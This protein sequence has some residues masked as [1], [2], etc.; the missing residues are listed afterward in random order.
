MTAP[1]PKGD[2]RDTAD[3]PQSLL[4]TGAS[5]GLGRALALH[6]AKPATVLHLWGRDEERL[7][8]TACAARNAGAMTQLTCMDLRDTEAAVREMLEQDRAA[9]FDMAY[10]VAG[11]GEIRAEN[12]IID[13]PD[14]VLRALQ[15]NCVAPAAMGAALAQ[16]MCLRGRGRIVMIGSAA[17]HHSLPFAA[18]Y[19]G[20]KAGL[21]RFTDAMRLA[22]KPYGVSITLAE[23]GF[24]DTPAARAISP[25]RPLQIS[26]EVA[27]RRIARAAM[28]GRPRLVTPWPF[29]V[30]Q[31]IDALLPR[32]ARDY[33]LSR[34]KP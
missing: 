3:T 34:L 2:I 32:I 33:M 17:A 4:I 14:L 27:A 13:D 24:I 31:K 10:F 5:G 19:A 12:A 22:V 15:T 29:A 26:P 8:E 11:T 25:D 23:P 21:A 9:E 16:G 28:Q 6:H 20:S 7:A 30:V 18:S 1:C